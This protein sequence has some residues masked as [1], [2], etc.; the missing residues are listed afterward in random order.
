MA[1]Y[2][3]RRG[4]PCIATLID[5]SKAF[6][7]CQFS[8]LF[9]KLKKKSLP[10][11]VIRTL[12]FVNEKQTAY[13]SWGTARSSQFGILNGTRQGSVLS[14]CFFG[15]YV[16]VLLLELRMSGVGSILVAVSLVLQAMQITL[17]CLLLVEVPWQRW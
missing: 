14:P 2:F 13:V 1:S 9:Q 11:I 15:I 4:T 3:L 17:F 8:V 12:I 16:L 10:A 7:M 6:D 5:C